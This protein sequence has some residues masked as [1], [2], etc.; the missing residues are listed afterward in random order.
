[1]AE[2]V[3]K[4]LSIPEPKKVEIKDFP[5]PK[6]VE[7]YSMVKVEIAPVCIEHQVY[8]EHRMEW[9]SDEDHQG[10][11][12]VGVIEETTP[13]SKFEVGDRVIIYQRNPC[14]ECFVCKRQLSDME[15]AC[16]TCHNADAPRF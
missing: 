12:G 3:N 11:E 15:V 9:H 2:K 1:M 7:G 14:E 6:I 10:H 8:H 4:I 13:G 5:F 16:G